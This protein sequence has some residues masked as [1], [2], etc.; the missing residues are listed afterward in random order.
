MWTFVN[1]FLFLWSVTG[2]INWRQLAWLVFPVGREVVGIH[3]PGFSSAIKAWHVLCVH[4]CAV[5]S[6]ALLINRVRQFPQAIYLL[7]QMIKSLRVLVSL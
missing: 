6:L 5:L 1:G 2:L 4:F 3:I 7:V